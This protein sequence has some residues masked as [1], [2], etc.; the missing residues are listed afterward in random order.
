LPF[1]FYYDGD[2]VRQS[3]KNGTDILK[4][5]DYVGEVELE[6]L[7][8][9]GFIEICIEG[10]GGMRIGDK[11]DVSV[12]NLE[13]KNVTEPFVLE[14]LDKRFYFLIPFHPYW[15][16]T[17]DDG[18]ILISYSIKSVL[19]MTTYSSETVRFHKDILSS[20]TVY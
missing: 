15:V 19:N 11:I 16:S 18:G 1:V 6:L 5:Y 8:K 20:S 9:T 2:F 14:K 4:R 12:G 10:Y 3:I 7:Q 17:L 13:T